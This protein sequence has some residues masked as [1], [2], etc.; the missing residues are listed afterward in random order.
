MRPIAPTKFLAR[1]RRTIYVSS[2]KKGGDTYFTF[3]GENGQK[4]QYSPK[5]RFARNGNLV[6]VIKPQN[7]V[8]KKIMPKRLPTNKPTKA[9]K[10][11][12]PVRSP[13]SARAARMLLLAAKRNAGALPV[14]RRARV[15]KPKA[16]PKPRASKAMS[17]GTKAAQMFT[18]I[19]NAK[20]KAAP[21]PRA[22]KAMS[23]GTKASQKF[24]RILNAK[25]KAPKAVP[26]PRA[27]KAMSPGTKAAQKFFRM[28]NT[29]PKKAKVA[30]RSPVGELNAGAK[31]LLKLNADS[32]RAAAMRATA[33]A[34]KRRLNSN[35]FAALMR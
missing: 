10:V 14:Y 12:A 20:P 5:A 33:A 23:P 6:R 32:R 13:G 25:P 31:M 29:K 30:K 21:K 9:N 24:F 15:A 8:P 28:L 4:K 7:V 19:L 18:R 35:P 16:A 1:N 3:G 27:S 11:A 17:P 2:S 26:K 34:K 22:S